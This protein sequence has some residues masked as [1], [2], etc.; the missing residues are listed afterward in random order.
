MTSSNQNNAIIDKKTL[1]KNYKIYQINAG[2]YNQETQS[3]DS[4]IKRL[5]KSLCLFCYNSN[6]EYKFAK[7]RIN[8]KLDIITFL[9][10]TSEIN[11]IKSLTLS[12]YYQETMNHLNKQKLKKEFNEEALI[13][14]VKDEK[15]I[16]LILY[17]LNKIKIDKLTF[18]DIYMIS[19]MKGFI[20]C[21]IKQN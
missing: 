8:K 7:D 19:N 5:L 11:H 12:P 17:Y 16:D 1:L 9:N 21:H 6:P 18:E 15:E 2:A 10:E 4:I 20:S 13:E 14:R 3:K